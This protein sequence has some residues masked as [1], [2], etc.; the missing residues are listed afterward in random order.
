MEEGRIQEEG[1]GARRKRKEEREGEEP[2][3][4]E[5]GWSQ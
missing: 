1:G 2:R 5:G 3:K 4:I